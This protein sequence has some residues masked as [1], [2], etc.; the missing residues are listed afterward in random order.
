MGTVEG[1]SPGGHVLAHP[2][3]G[4]ALISSRVVLL[5]AGDLQHGVGVL[6]LHLAGEGHAVGPLPGDLRHR[7][8]R[9]GREKKQVHHSG[10]F[11]TYRPSLKHLE[12]SNNEVPD[13]ALSPVPGTSGG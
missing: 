10:S 3:L 13:G 8:G 4:H 6:H 5:E 1:Q 2:V 11:E 9:G 12:Q 7:A